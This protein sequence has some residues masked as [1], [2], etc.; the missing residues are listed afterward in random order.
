MFTILFYLFQMAFLL[1]IKLMKKNKYKI[2]KI[3]KIKIN[4]FFNLKKNEIF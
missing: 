4:Y 3:K 1:L 2:I